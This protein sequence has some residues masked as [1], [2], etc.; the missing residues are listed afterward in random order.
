VFVAKP[1]GEFLV[2]S[3]SGKLDWETYIQQYQRSLRNFLKTP[4]SGTKVFRVVLNRVQAANGS[5]G[6]VVLSDP[7]IVPQALDQMDLARLPPEVAQEMMAL[8]P[9]KFRLATVELAWSTQAIPTLNIQGL[10]CWESK[11]VGE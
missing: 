7:C 8:T 3:Q 1:Q 6:A 9:G 5:G 10:V 2:L 11:G 4:S